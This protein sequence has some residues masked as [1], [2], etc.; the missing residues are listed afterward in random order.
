MHYPGFPDNRLIVGG[1]D[2]TEE[3]KMVLV[4]GYALSPPEPKTYTVDIPGG[5]G[6]IDLTESVFGDVVYNNRNQTFK[7]YVI[8]VEN[9]EHLKTSVSNFLHG[10]EF[11]YKM[12]M[13]PLYTYHGRFT[14]SGYEHEMYELGRVGIINVNI[15]ARPYKYKDPII[16]SFNAISGVQL[17][18]ESGRKNVCPTIEVDNTCTVIFDNRQYE[19]QPGTW[20]IN[21]IMFKKGFNTIYFNTYEVR[22]LTWRDFLTNGITWGGLKTQPV[23]EWYKSR[24]SAQVPIKVWN[25]L[26]EETWQTLLD[27]NET[28][29]DQLY[30]TN[31]KY[32]K[33]VYIKYEWGDL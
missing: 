22:N 30:D 6:Q 15:S 19:L 25:D 7:F 32:F 9:F 14:I 31:L 20:K 12:T 23:F 24:G 8:K 18:F 21:D 3:F 17:S 26:S 29:D 27:S 33:P 13:D 10:K 28:W 1:V 5:N 16:K 2:L 11:D 4:D